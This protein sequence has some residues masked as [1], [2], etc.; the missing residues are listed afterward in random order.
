MGDQ[1]TI[2]GSNGGNIRT[3]HP[4][5]RDHY[6]KVLEDAGQ[7]AAVT[8]APFDGDGRPDKFHTFSGA[9]DAAETPNPPRVS[10]MQR[11]AQLRGMTDGPT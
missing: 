5:K 3:D 8:T 6:V 7:T 1:Y 9:R 11:L 4:L 10:R 2:T